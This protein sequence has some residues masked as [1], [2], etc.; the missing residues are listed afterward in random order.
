MKAPLPNEVETIM[1]TTEWKQPVQC[2]CLVGEA[3]NLPDGGCGCVGTGLQYPTNAIVIP[4]TQMNDTEPQPVAITTAD[5][6][7]PFNI[8][9]WVY[10]YRWYLA[11][12]AAVIVLLLLLRKSGTK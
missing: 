3:V 4:N 12:G 6:N 9:T 10:N 2:N 8:Q 7:E 1:E 5:T 11:G